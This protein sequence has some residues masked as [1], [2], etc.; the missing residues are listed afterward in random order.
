MKSFLRKTAEYLLEQHA[1]NDLHKVCIVLPS[2]RGVLYL[3]KELAKMGDKPF[4]SPQIYTIE[5]FSLEMTQ[6]ELVDPTQLLLQAFDVFKE[7]DPKVD[8][9]RF[10]TWGAMMLKDFDTIDMYL[11]DPRHLFSFLSEA[12]AIERWGKEYGI[13]DTSTLITNNTK[14]YFSLYDHL[15]EVYARLQTRLHDQNLAYRGMVYRKLIENL[16]SE[17]PLPIQFDQLYFVG[18]NALSKAEEEMIR[19]FIQQGKTQTLWDVDDF[20][21]K[22]KY[23]RAGNW[24]RDYSNPSAKNYLSKGPFKWMS[25]DLTTEPKRLEIIGLAN[26]SAQIYAALDTI[27]KWQNDYGDQEQ[28]ALVLGDEYLLDQVVQY[29]G[30]YKSRLNFTMGYSMKKTQIFSLLE[31]FWE[32]LKYSSDGRFSTQWMEQLFRHPLM[33][34]YFKHLKNKSK[35]DASKLLSDLGSKSAMRVKLDDILALNVQ[36]P[37]LDFLF[38]QHDVSFQQIVLKIKLLTKTLMMSIPENEWNEQAEALMITHDLTETIHDLLHDRQDISV[39]SGKSLFNQLLQQKKISFEGADVRTLNVMGLLETRTL[40]FDRVIVMSLNE[41]SLP[42]TRKRDSLIPLDI[43]SMSAFALPTFTQADAVTSYHFYR[44]LQR[45]KEI[46]FTYV[47]PS[48]K[49]SVKEMSRFI[50]QIKYD[51]VKANPNLTVS[52]PMVE[53]P[54]RLFSQTIAEHHTIVKSPEIQTK[55]LSKL[56][57]R[58]LSPSAISTFA[59]C[60]IK[61]Y[62]A[63]VLGLRAEKNRDDEMGADVFGTWVH[64]VLELADEDILRNKSGLYQNDDLEARIANIDQKLDEAM[65]IIQAS[66]GIFEVEKGFNFILKSVAKTLLENYFK[67]SQTWE[68]EVVKI[69]ALEESLNSSL[70]IKIK[71]EDVVV[72]LQGRVDRIDVLGDNVLRI[73]DYKTG[74]VESKDLKVENSLIEELTNSDLKAKLFQLWLYKYLII[75]ELKLPISDRKEFNQQLDL[76]NLE[77]KPGI[78]SFRN[79]KEKVLSAQLDFEPGENIDQFIQH[80]E[81]VIHHWVNRLLD[82]SENFERTQQIENCQYCDFKVICGREV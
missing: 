76:T 8:F 19:L 24:L 56:K 32:L 22:N 10:I 55:I 38:F 5:E 2:Q 45:P 37:I 68:K 59:T 52:E 71:G 51:W 64:K 57:D 18:F 16:G 39:K 41:G 36:I 30:K 40:D 78:I 58:G 80:S 81:E 50:K 73:I 12:K 21:I 42:G 46:V 47:L 44:L 13:E 15:L 33:L 25:N 53:F 77:F 31:I 34:G 60:S 61:Y 7:V 69:I 67:Q 70:T 54:K 79:F 65:D 28:I 6:M 49:S 11:V 26:P 27:E 74:K 29:I 72:K 20:Y 1:L 63:Q 62:Y 48:E 17:K 9:D 66:E 23:H 75:K 4:L 35:I 82:E 3:K 14:A 43:A